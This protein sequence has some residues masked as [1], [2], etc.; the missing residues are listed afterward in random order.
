MSAWRGPSWIAARSRSIQG[1][2]ICEVMCSTGE[3][4]VSASTCA[5]AALPAAVPVLVMTTPSLRDT[6]A[7]ASAM[8][9]APAS[10]RAGTKRMRPWRAIASRIGMLWMEITPNTVL[11]PIS[12]SA[13]AITSP[14]GPVTAASCISDC[15]AVVMPMLHVPRDAAGDFKLR[16]GDETG[17]RRAQEGDGPRHLLGLAQPLQRNLLRAR[18]LAVPLR[19]CLRGIRTHRKA[20]LPLAGIDQ[21]EQHGID[22]DARGK[23]ERQRFDQILRAGSRRRGRDHVGFGLIR[24]ERVHGEDRRRI[25]L[26]EHRLE[27]A[28]RMDLAEELQLQLLPPGFIG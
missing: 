25:A 20:A 10:P 19:A 18:D 6:R 21:P 1:R 3:P 8:F 22:A 27:G 15:A 4:A 11:T 24:Q 2:S 28:H 26:V 13:W 7:K 12:A 5:P 16:A 17:D 23:L 9:M 14:T